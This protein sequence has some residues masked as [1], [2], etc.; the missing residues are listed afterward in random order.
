MVTDPAFV[1]GKGEI[2]SS[3]VSHAKFTRSSA[4]CRSV[5]RSIFGK[6]SDGKWAVLSVK[7]KG[8]FDIQR[9]G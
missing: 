2:V 3:Q 6:L 5:A 9:L 1:A 7:R 8:G 4:N